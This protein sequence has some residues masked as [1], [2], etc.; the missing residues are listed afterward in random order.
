MRPSEL[1]SL[2]RSWSA[3]LRHC[4]FETSEWGLR[5]S[6]IGMAWRRV[7]NEVI[8]FF[9]FPKDVRRLIYTTNAIEALNSK[10]LTV[11]N[12]AAPFEPEAT[13]Q[14]MMRL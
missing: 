13:S 4:A 8:P 2:G 12:C 9:A 1:V 6:A 7:W 10:F 11:P 3:T 5:Y 14:P